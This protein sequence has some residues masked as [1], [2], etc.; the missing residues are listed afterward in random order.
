MPT[1]RAIK[2]QRPAL[3]SLKNLLANSCCQVVKAAMLDSRILFNL[4]ENRIREL[5][6][7]ATPHSSWP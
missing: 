2:V 1:R 6:S 3:S 5:F 7:F 4:N